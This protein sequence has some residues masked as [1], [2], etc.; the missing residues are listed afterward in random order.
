MLKSQLPAASNSLSAALSAAAPQLQQQA[1][2]TNKA[3]AQP[4][5]AAMQLTE[6]NR[7]AELINN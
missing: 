3:V 7:G 6:F 1:I 2:E 5:M 4:N